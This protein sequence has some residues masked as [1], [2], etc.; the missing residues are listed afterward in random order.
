MTMLLVERRSFTVIGDAV[1]RA[2]AHRG[3]RVLRDARI[4][5]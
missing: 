4:V 1:L 2:G 5:R 3:E